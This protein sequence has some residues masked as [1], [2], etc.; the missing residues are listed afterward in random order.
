VRLKVRDLHT[1]GGYDALRVIRK[2]GKHDVL[3]IHPETAQRLRAYL[4]AASHGQDRDGPLVRR[5]NGSRSGQ[6]WRR[7]LRPERVE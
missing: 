6:D 5:L 4:A 3:V 7:P 2:G 1:T